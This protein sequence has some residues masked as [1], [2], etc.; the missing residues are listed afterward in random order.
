MKNNLLSTMD[1]PTTF[2]AADFSQPLFSQ[3][4]CKSFTALND[5]SKY[6]HHLF[7]P[8]SLHFSTATLVIFHSL[9]STEENNER[10]REMEREIERG[11]WPSS[12]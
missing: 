10:E 12:Q 5:T 7:L 11:S 8:H 1:V 2:V 6:L 3:L 4:S 9:Y